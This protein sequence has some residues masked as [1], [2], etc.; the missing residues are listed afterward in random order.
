MVKSDQ[1]RRATR[2]RTALLALQTSNVPFRDPRV[3]LQ[4]AHIC[5]VDKCIL[6]E[7]EIVRLYAHGAPKAE[8]ISKFLR[9]L[10]RNLGLA[11]D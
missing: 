8:H 4:S 3:T 1:K 7:E 2:L 6:T 10:R 5:V 9:D 11:Y